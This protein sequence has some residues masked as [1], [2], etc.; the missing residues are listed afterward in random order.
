MNDTQELTVTGVCA[1]FPTNSHLQM[2]AVIQSP[3][4]EDIP[5]NW[6][7]FG[8]YN[9]IRLKEGS[10]PQAFESKINNLAM[11]KM[12]ITL[13]TTGMEFLLFLEP[14]T[15]IHLYSTLSYNLGNN[16]SITYVYVFSILSRTAKTLVY[17]TRTEIKFL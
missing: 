3:E 4:L 14:V 8:G 5:Q 1:D 16:G 17:S 2:N 15:D 10:D 13:E 11:E 7:S 12:G 9:Y 6:G